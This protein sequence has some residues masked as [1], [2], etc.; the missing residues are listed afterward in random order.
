MFFVGFQISASKNVAIDTAAMT[1]CICKSYPYVSPVNIMPVLRM[2]PKHSTSAAITPDITVIVG[3]TKSNV[4]AENFI[5]L[6]H[7]KTIQ[8]SIP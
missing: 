1:I 8:A 3:I 5:K 2:F 7:I 4:L 6:L